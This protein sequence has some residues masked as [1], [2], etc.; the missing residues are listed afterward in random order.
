MRLDKNNT[1]RRQGWEEFIQSFHLVLR[2]AELFSSYSY[3]LSPASSMIGIS[4]YYQAMHTM[5]THRVWSLFLTPNLFSL[6]CFRLLF[7]MNKETQFYLYTLQQLL[8]YQITVILSLLCL[9]EQLD[10][11][12]ISLSSQL[13]LSNFVIIFLFYSGLYQQVMKCGFQKRAQT[14]ELNGGKIIVVGVSTTFLFFHCSKISFSV[15]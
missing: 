3:I 2:E 4:K 14:S 5:L 12:F 13:I 11:E 9:V 1:C 10:P 15:L 8:I 6:L 7:Q